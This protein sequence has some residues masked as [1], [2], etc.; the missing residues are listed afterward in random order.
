MDE[1][2]FVNAV[3][4]QAD[5]DLLLDVQNIVVN[6]TNHGY[7]AHEFLLALP[8]TRIRYIHVDG[9]RDEAPD[10]K[11]DPHRAAVSDQDWALLDEAYS[12]PGRR[13]TLRERDF[14]FPPF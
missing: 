11:I 14:K 6:A 12:V 4:A 5:C 7:D 2:D 3:L 13:P 10:L 8:Q 9:H 1:I